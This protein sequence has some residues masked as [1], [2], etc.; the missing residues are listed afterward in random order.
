M[1]IGRSVAA[2]FQLR[3]SRL[4]HLK[5]ATAESFRGETNFGDNRTFLIIDFFT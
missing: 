4:R 2:A 5:V 3:N 1:F